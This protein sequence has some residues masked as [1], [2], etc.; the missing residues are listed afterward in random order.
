MADMK[1][2]SERQKKNRARVLAMPV[3]DVW[4]NYVAKAEKKTYGVDE[5]YQVTSWLT[6]YTREEIDQHLEAKT[7]FQDFFDQATMNPNAQLITGVVCGVRVEDMDDT[8]MRRLRWLDK[9]VDELAKGKK[10]ESIL[11]EG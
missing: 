5:L 7:S 3:A 9:L 8:E 4:P 2:L 6:G 10:M 11:R 1:N